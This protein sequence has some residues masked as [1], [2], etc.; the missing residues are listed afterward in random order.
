MFKPLNSPQPHVWGLRSNWLCLGTLF[1][2]Q[3]I[4]ELGMVS[5]KGVT[6]IGTGGETTNGDVVLPLLN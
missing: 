6:Q 1:P 2:R 3:E 5:V 4:A